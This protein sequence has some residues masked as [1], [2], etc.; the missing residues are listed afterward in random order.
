MDTVAIMTEDMTTADI[1]SDI[2]GMLYA[3]CTKAMPVMNSVSGSVAFMLVR[4]LTMERPIIATEA[5]TPQNWNL[6]KAC[7]HP[8][9]NHFMKSFCEARDRYP[10]TKH[11]GPITSDTP[12]STSRDM[13]STLMEA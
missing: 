3:T 8:A 12:I 5:K 6:K 13:S 2:F 1:F 7:I 9:R 10:M 11:I 4:K